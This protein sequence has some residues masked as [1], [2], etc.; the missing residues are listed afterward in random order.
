MM[1]KI[2]DIRVST[3]RQKGDKRGVP[4]QSIWSEQVEHQQPDSYETTRISEERRMRSRK[5]Y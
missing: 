1:K 3:V 4:P 5:T 2:L